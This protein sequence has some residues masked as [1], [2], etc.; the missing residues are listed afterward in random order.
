MWKIAG[1]ILKAGEKKRIILEPN[2]EG[3]EIP[4][5]LICGAKQGKTLL[6]TA[7]IHSGEYPG[8]PASARLAA[9]IDPLRL[10]GNILIMH[11]VNTS[12]F[13]DRVPNVVPEDGTNLNADYPG[14]PDG[15]AGARIADYFVREIFPHIDFLVD[16]HSGSAMEKLTPCLFFPNAPKVR[17]E[18]LNA[19][20]ALNIPYLIESSNRSG[21]CGYAA[22]FCGV[23]GL[24]LERGYNSICRQDWIS[25]YEQDLCLLLAHLEMYSEDSLKAVCPKKIYTKAVYLESD[26]K[27]LWFPEVE[28]DGRVRCGQI[29]GHIE[30]FYGTVLKEYRA[31]ADGTVFYY[32]CALPVTPGEPLV[33]YGLEE[34][35]EEA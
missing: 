31:Q 21:E 26:I 8:I 34:G 7:G 28:A 30:D 9:Q 35:M 13:W 5:T 22:N 23:P 11:C 14:S 33:A 24:L 2:V 17:G 6:I 1:Q 32:T 29:L 12:G 15:G 18:A 27:G 25:A 20:K 10:C 16:L 19:A 4:A 3:Y